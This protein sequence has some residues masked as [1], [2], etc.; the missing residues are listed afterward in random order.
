MPGTGS[1]FSA[2]C[3]SVTPIRPAIPAPPAFIDLLCH[4]RRSTWMM[5][6]ILRPQF[7]S[8]ASSGT[9]FRHCCPLLYHIRFLFS[10]RTQKYGPAAWTSVPAP[11]PVQPG[12]SASPCTLFSCQ[13]Y[14]MRLDCTE[15]PMHVDVECT[16]RGHDG[17]KKE[18]IQIGK[19]TASYAI[20]VGAVKNGLRAHPI[21]RGGDPIFCRHR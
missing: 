6:R 1:F 5:R 9:R 15:Q 20:V 14:A 10:I 21:D 2:E 4:R 7:I 11:H 12:Y 17:I 8:R 16:C 3:F 18:C 19:T 13:T